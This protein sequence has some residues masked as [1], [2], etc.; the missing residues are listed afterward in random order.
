MKL[1]T[2]SNGDSSE[3]PAN[4]ILNLILGADDDIYVYNGQQLNRIKNIGSNSAAIRNAIFQK[5]K[6]IKYKYGSDTGMIVLIKAT[7]ASTYKNV[8][9]ALDEMLICNVKTYELMDAANDE[10]KAIKL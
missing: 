8:V 3:L 2:T 4:K 5:K 1:A 7:D 10:L 6:E 9:N